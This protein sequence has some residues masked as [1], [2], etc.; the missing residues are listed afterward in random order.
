[1]LHWSAEPAQ[2][3][4]SPSE[5]DIERTWNSPTPFAQPNFDER[6]C[7][8]VDLELKHHIERL[9]AEPGSEPEQVDTHLPQ[10]QD[11]KN[12]FQAVAVIVHSGG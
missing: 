1:M 12:C 8:A 5:K 2:D 3:S 6:S 11:C 7:E 9:S 10:E 4:R